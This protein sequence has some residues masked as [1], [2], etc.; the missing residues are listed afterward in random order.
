MSTH[1]ITLGSANMN[2]KSPLFIRLLALLAIALPALAQAAVSINDIAFAALPGNKVQITVKGSGPL[3]K[4]AS[5][6][7]DNPPRLAIDFPGVTSSVPKQTQDINIGMARSVQALEA[8]NR[9][10]VVVSLQS[11]APYDVQLKGNEAIITVSGGT[12]EGI[13]SASAQ[14]T[15]KQVRRDG[16]KGN[17]QYGVR[18]IDFR[19]GDSGEGRLLITLTNPNTVVDMKKQGADIIVDLANT[20]IPP[21]LMRKLDVTDFATPVKSV[22]AEAAGMNTRLT[23]EATGIYEHLAYQTDNNYVVELRPLSAQEEAK[24][25][26]KTYTGERLSL[27]FQDI[28]VRSVLQLLADFTSMNL[29][30]SDSVKGNITLR[31]QNVPWDHALDI[32]LK[33]KGLDMRQKENVMRI[34]PTAEIA[35]AEKLELESQKQVQE[36]APL[37][38]EWF[39]LNFAKAEDFAT[40]IRGS[41]A[42]TGTAGQPGTVRDS[43]I[44]ERGSIT[45]DKR[46]NTLL[47]KDSEENLAQIRRLVQKLDIPTQQVLIESRIVNASD[48]FAKDLGVR[49]GVAGSGHNGTLGQR[50]TEHFYTGGSLGAGVNEGYIA[51]GNAGIPNANGTTG[52]APLMDMLAVNLPASNP[53]SAVSFV[54]GRAFSHIISLELSAMQSEGRG[55]IISSPRVMTADQHK[56][57]IEQG[58]EIA[59]QEAASSGATTTSFKK[60]VLK[61]DVTPQITPDDRIIMDLEVTQDEPQYFPNTPV[62]GLR[63]RNVETQVLVN[64]GETVVLGGVF[65]QD[66]RFDKEQTPLLGDLPYLG[67]LFKRKSQRDANTELLI[68]VT[69]KIIKEGLNQVGLRPGKGK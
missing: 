68:F 17:G 34:G 13:A 66:K 62:P 18:N 61:L 52:V 39:R 57:T 3:P 63:T 30:V 56:A 25:R 44:S 33:A 53:T 26:E 2:R 24:V 59:Y 40:M 48:E 50:D 67:N 5:F 65:T 47:V 12:N 10:R 41:G 8:G 43:F 28:E 54:L 29:V 37:H 58:F 38:S 69:P 16:D 21:Q 15:V 60:A 11:S 1:F 23:L 32:I 22:K 7:T 14:Q 4:P 64:N 45:M 20:R 35:A 36:L 42:T 27:N 55:E 19:R 46:T 6:N 31:L 51:A 49:L 9:T